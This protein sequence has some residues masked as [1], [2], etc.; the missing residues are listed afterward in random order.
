M[1]LLSLSITQHW[2][3]HLILTKTP[4]ILV[5]VQT[6]SAEKH[7]N[8]IYDGRCEIAEMVGVQSMPCPALD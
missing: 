8:E 2:Q 5:S 7:Q 4:I 1:G 6:D 3:F